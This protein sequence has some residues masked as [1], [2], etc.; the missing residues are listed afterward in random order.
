MAKNFYKLK[1]RVP[2]HEARNHKE[3]W[4]ELQKAKQEGRAV[5]VFTDDPKIVNVHVFPSAAAAEAFQ[6]RT[7]G[8][9][10]IRDE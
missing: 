8:S 5:R 4:A 10:I 9:C 2:M 6:Q 3:M 1:T 7:R